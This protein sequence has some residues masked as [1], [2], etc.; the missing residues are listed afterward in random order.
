[1]TQFHISL[2]TFTEEEALKFYQQQLR[3]RDCSDI[4][5]KKE[6]KNLPEIPIL[7]G[8]SEQFLIIPFLLD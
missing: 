1:L 8:H 3:N 6:E 4:K 7:W 5:K 2:Y